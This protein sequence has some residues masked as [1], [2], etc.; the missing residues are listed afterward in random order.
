MGKCT[1][2]PP[3]NDIKAT[4]TVSLRWLSKLLVIIF[5]F[6]LLLIIKVHTR[7]K[8]Y[9]KCL[10]NFL[11]QQKFSIVTLAVKTKLVDLRNLFEQ[12][13]NSKVIYTLW[14]WTLQRLRIDPKKSLFLMNSPRE[15]QTN[16]L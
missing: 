16:R 4:Y 8:N 12:Q 3:S 2:V 14:F 13:I 5:G 15:E 9:K 7:G 10:T 6:W 1:E 11:V